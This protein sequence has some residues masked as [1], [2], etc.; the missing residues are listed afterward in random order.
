MNNKSNRMA[1]LF[2][3]LLL[4]LQCSPGEM[5][6]EPVIVNAVNTEIILMYSPCEVNE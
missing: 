2:K 4:Y 5:T 1:L 3:Q 6:S